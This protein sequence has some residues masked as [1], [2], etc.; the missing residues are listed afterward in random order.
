MKKLLAI[1]LALV[2][3]LSVSSAGFADEGMALSVEAVG[4]KGDKIDSVAYIPM[5]TTS[6]YFLAMSEVFTQMFN[7]AGFKTEYSSPDFDP[8]R[9]QEILENY[10]TVGYDCIVVF[11]INAA[12]INSAV[13]TA[14]EQGVKV[15]CQVNMTDECDGWV[16]TDA[17]ALG[18]GAAKL[19]ANWVEEN[20]PDAAEGGIK[21]AIIEIRTDDNNSSI[22]EG[23]EEIK[24][25]CSKLDI[26]TTV[27]VT[28]ETEAAAQQAAENLYVTN[29]DVQVIICNTSTL[30]VGVDSFM[31][32]MSSPIDDLSSVAIFTTGSDN[33]LF[34]MLASSAEN[35]SV[36]RGVS[37]YAPMLVGAQILTNIILNL[38][39]GIEGEQNFQADPQYLL[40]ASNI[41]DYLAV[42]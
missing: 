26:V 4:E 33:A 15:V 21:A 9:Q 2:L 8:V 37:S 24:D 36:I 39:N 42:G 35:A 20:Y 7:D 18:Q 3:V 16:G 1:V 31:T 40:T 11:P 41:G 27:T 23:C 34:E 6:D 14:R 13:E 17:L 10:V 29:P 12:S 25:L 30:A 5:S 28:E 32:S 22:A 38:S 19:A